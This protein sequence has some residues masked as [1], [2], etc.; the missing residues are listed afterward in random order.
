MS[1]QSRKQ[2]RVGRRPE[3]KDKLPTRRTRINAKTYTKQ[4]KIHGVYD[5]HHPTRAKC[6]PYANQIQGGQS[7]AQ[8][9]YTS[10]SHDQYNN[11]RA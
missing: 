8:E 5:G 2:K 7:D 3:P 6:Q 1:F 9:I 10:I 4:D 11:T